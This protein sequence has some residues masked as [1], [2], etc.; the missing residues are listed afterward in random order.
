MRK[1]QFDEETVNEI[2]QFI[3][4]GHTILET[5]NKFTLKYDTL[6]RVMKENGIECFHKEKRN[7]V[8][9]K[10]AEVPM[11]KRPDVVSLVCKL[12][13][14]TDTLAADICKQA[15]VSYEDYMIIVR[16]NFTEYEISKRKHRTYRNCRIVDRNGVCHDGSGYVMCVKPRWYTGRPSSKYV[17]EHTLVM[18]EALGLTEMPK[19][20]VVHHINGN[21]QDNRL[22][23][24]ALATMSGH[25]SIHRIQES[26]CKVQRL[27]YDGVASSNIEESEAPGNDCDM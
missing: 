27:S 7:K 14:D 8:A 23:N 24:L 11:W 22:C 21:K 20:F 18:C 16:N 15:H 13:S 9:Q 4:S 6:R 10:S 1:I 12:F 5:M 2:R 25:T 26:L 19:G 17:F 3:E